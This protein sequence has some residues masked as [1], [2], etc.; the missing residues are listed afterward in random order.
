MQIEGKIVKGI[1]GFYYVNCH[2][3]G[4]SDLY[5]CKAKG[6]FRKDKVKPL[7][8]DNVRIQIVSEEEKQGNVQEILAR[9]NYLIRPE[10]A[11]VD[12]ALILFAMADPLPNLNL[13][14]RF[15]V[16]MEMQGVETVIC[17]NKLDIVSSE[18]EQRL[19]SIYEKCVNR[20]LSVSSRENIGINS[21]RELLRGKTTVLAGP[22]GV[23]K[24]SILN[25]IFPDAGSKT[26]AVSEKIRRGKHTTR[27]S[28]LFCVGDRTYLFDTP[29]FSSLR[30]PD[31]DKEELKNYF[32]EFIPYE[33]MCRFIG[34]THTHEPDCKVKE[35]LGQQQISPVRY[36]NYVQMFEEL[37]DMGK[38]K[39]NER[40]VRD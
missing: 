3:A 20:V 37:K 10:V 6:G 19:V 14:D 22:S 26:G 25:Q 21:V 36:R 15:L 2:T 24:S 27:H 8:G 29:G 23:G 5:E 35:A 17:F 16:M 40:K 12:Q 33:G 31:M 1:A 32:T 4:G 13:L 39:Y 38:Q 28:E 11:N 18:E 9:K 7:V 34:C 30:I